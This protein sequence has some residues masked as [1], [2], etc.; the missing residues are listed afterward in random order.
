MIGFVNGVPGE[1]TVSRFR[2]RMGGDFDGAFA[3]LVKHVIEMTEVE[4]HNREILKK[5]NRIFNIQKSF[6]HI[7]FKSFESDYWLE[8]GLESD[9]LLEI[10]CTLADGKNPNIF[11]LM[12]E[13]REKAKRRRIWILN[14]RHI[15]IISA[16]TI[17]KG[18]PRGLN[19]GL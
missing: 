14:W 9:A 10:F 15:E 12:R 3:D 19:L 6:L 8:E 18:F 5:F 17:T 11:C 16:E 1:A 4:K 2:A 7:P 13:K